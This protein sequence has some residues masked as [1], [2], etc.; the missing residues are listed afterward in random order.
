MPSV[1]GPLTLAHSLI[2]SSYHGNSDVGLRLFFLNKSSFLLEKKVSAGIIYKTTLCVPRSEGNVGMDPA[3]RTP[4]GS[5]PDYRV[6]LTTAPVPITAN[7]RERPGKFLPPGILV[8]KLSLFQ[9]CIP[10][11]P[12]EPQTHS[13]TQPQSQAQAHPGL[14]PGPLLTSA[15]SFLFLPHPSPSSMWFFFPSDEAVRCLPSWP[16]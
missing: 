5:L 1:C 16:V 14:S 9:L 13:L 12:T 4:T 11:G 7:P 10:Q 8:G 6:P 3:A 2:P 15:T